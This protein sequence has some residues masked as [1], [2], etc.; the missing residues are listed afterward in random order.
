MTNAYL[1]LSSQGS[2][3][4]PILQ[5]LLDG[6]LPEDPKEGKRI[7]REA[8]NYTVVTGHLYKRG[9][10]QPLLKCVK[11]GDTEYIL[12][13]IHEGCCGHHIGGK[14]LAQRIIRAGYFWPTVIRDS[15]QLVKNCDKCQRHANIHQASPHQL[16]II[17]AERP[18]G[19]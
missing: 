7:K 14:T 17:S 6:T 16:S 19:T 10:S 2:W 18:F 8:A 13:E 9:F 4:Y 11:P 5:Y 1:T 3:T 15:M 12:R